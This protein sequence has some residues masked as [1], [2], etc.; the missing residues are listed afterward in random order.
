MK[1]L[2]FQ[3]KDIKRSYAITRGIFFKCW[4][5]LGQMGERKT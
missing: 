3:F 1:V 2:G 4:K 5:G